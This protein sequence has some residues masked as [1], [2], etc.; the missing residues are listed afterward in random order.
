MCDGKQSGTGRRIDDPKTV[1]PAGRLL[2]MALAAGPEGILQRSVIPSKVLLPDA[3][4][5]R[6]ERLAHRLI[7]SKFTCAQDLWDFQLELL[8][9]QREVQRAITMAKKDARTDKTKR[10]DVEHLRIIR[11]LARRLGD[12]FAWVLLGLDRR[13]ISALGDGPRVP[14]ASEEGHG[15]IGVK[16]VA[17]YLSGEGWG[18]PLIHDVTDCLRIGDVTFISPGEELSREL[19]TVE[20]KTRLLA[21]TGPDEDGKGM[22]RYEVSLLAPQP[23]DPPTATVSPAD[24]ASRAD[25]GDGSNELAARRR[26]RRPDRREEQ[27]LRRMSKALARRSAEDG[28][29]VNIPGETPMVS[30]TFQSEADEHWR[31]LRRVVRAARRDGYASAVVE[32]ALMYVAIYDRDGI[33]DE[34]VKNPQ[35]LADLSASGLLPKDRAP[36]RD[37]LIV[38][39]IPPMHRGGDQGFLPFYLYSV[40]WN[41]VSDLMANRLCII[42]LVNPGQI[43]RALEVEGFRVEVPS[44]L[45]L[46]HESV[47]LYTRITTD[48]GSAY[49]MMLG[50]MSHHIREIIYE[51]KGV[52]YVVETAKA[53]VNAAR[54]TVVDHGRAR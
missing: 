54:T 17:M 9:L 6:L 25:D 12:A 51:F 47:R 43:L 24:T 48:S 32:D 19:R 28:E 18:F 23:L 16:G 39:Q 20:I 53:M 37:S 50:G 5:R 8:E 42:V 40:P 34:H 31:T 41:A 3:Y 2:G 27:Q 30:L 13:T 21:E 52:S 10:A 49:M 15:D 44:D 29:V 45:D 33:T 7:R 1:T 4:R 35:L 26:P 38:N 11:W 36:G 14:V 46:S 22:S